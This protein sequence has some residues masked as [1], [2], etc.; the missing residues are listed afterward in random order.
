MSQTSLNL[1]AVSIFSI[2][3][4]ALIG[5][6][7]NI[8]PTIPAGITAIILVLATFDTLGWQNRG[9]TILLDL[10]SSP[11]ERDRVVTHEAGHFLVAYL[12][13]IPIESYTLT[14]WE[15]FRK[16]YAGKGGVVFDL[17]QI[18]RENLDQF[19]FAKLL[20]HFCTVWSA[21]VAAEMIMYG[22]AYGGEDDQNRITTA[23]AE[24]GIS[25]AVYKQRV[26]LALLRAKQLIENNQESFLNLIEAMKAGLS[27]QE[28]YQAIALSSLKVE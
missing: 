4:F 27:L 11:E 18:N 24:A 6:I 5:P 21:G 16:G 12:L 10:L 28:C 3:L 9:S 20:D 15:A 1:L 17:R 7:L 14:A 19:Q 13:N 8:S 23:L 25:P 22:E 2:T 26:N